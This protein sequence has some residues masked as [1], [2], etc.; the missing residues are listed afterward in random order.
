MQKVA[1]TYLNRI[2]W[3]DVVVGANFRRYSLNSEGTL[4][5][6]DNDGEEIS[7]NEYGAYAQIGKKL[8]NDNLRLQG[9]L[10][11]DKNENFKG[12]LSPRLSAV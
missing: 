7:F 2:D 8:L 10:R 11:Y 12:Q 6:L 4:F 9:S 3:A 1:G 5:A